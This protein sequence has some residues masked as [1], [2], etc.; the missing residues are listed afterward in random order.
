M[1]IS[2]Q[3]VPTINVES[4]RNN[5]IIKRLFHSYLRD[6]ENLRLVSPYHRATQVE[7]DHSTNLQVRRS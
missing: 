1:L 2:T 7:E 5:L 3:Q 4:I 6:C